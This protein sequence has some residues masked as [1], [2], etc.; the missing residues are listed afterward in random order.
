VIYYYSLIQQNR[1]STNRNI[2]VIFKTF[3]QGSILTTLPSSKP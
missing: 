3:G 1:K 2:S